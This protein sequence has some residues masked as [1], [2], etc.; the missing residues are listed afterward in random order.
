[1]GQ[2]DLLHLSLLLTV[3]VQISH[4]ILQR[5]RRTLLLLWILFSSTHNAAQL[6]HLNERLGLNLVLSVLLFTLNFLIAYYFKTH[7]RILYYLRLVL[8]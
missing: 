5:I 3:L 4:L 1:M 8:D 2:V 7:E 6:R